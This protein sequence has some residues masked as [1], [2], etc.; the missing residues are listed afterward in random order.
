MARFPDRA[1]TA[2]WHEQHGASAPKAGEIAPDFELYDVAG[3]TS[4]RLSSYRGDRPVAL[5][6]GSFT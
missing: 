2:E 1:A 4:V 5:V 6:F 3:E